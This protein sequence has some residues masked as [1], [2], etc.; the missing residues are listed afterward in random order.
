MTHSELMTLERQEQIVQLVNQAGRITVAEL[1]AHFGVSETTIRRDLAALA[2][3]NLVR[4]T[5]G[6]VMRATPV[7][8]SEIPIM[9]R[10]NE[11]AA[12][13]ERIGAATAELI[14]DGE[15]LLL[16]GGSTGLAV[17]RH[18]NHHR[19]LTIITESLLV[20][21]ELLRQEHHRLILLGGTVEP[22]ELAVRGTLARQV[23]AQLCV[24][25]VIIGARAVSV[26]RGVSAETP[27]EAE[28]LRA[29]LNCGEHTILVTDSS[30]FHL[31]A[32]ARLCPLSAINT[33]VTDSGLDAE[34]AQQVQEMGVYLIMA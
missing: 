15:T 10:Q 17:A 28:F 6:G 3:R 31:S 7:A 1:S 24:D 9:Q 5:H 4:R 32:L 26:E 34:I 30:K 12:E 29:F 16:A 23:L 11:H 25:K 33:L 13:K 22:D 27:E 8:T 14:R 21:H 19:N 18:L 2:A 20:V